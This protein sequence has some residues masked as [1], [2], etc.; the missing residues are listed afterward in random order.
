MNRTQEALGLGGWTNPTILV[1]HVCDVLLFCQRLSCRR[2]LTIS[3]NPSFR[4][5][6]LEHFYWL[7][8]RLNSSNIK[9][10]EHAL[11]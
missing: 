8:G 1:D 11:N 10:G 7:L 2:R 6:I 9:E 3:S 4:Q 5:R